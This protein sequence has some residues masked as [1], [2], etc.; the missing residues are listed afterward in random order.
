M[1]LEQARSALNVVSDEPFNA[2]APSE[3]FETSI[4]PTHL[5]F[6]RSNF[7]LPVHDG[8]LAIG[9]AVENSFTLTLDDLR[10]MPR[11]ELVVTLEC[12]G[13]ARLGQ[14]PL[15][16]GEPWHSNAVSAA[17]WAGASLRNVLEKA[18]PLADAVVASFEGADHGPYHQHAD[19]HFARSLP[20]ELALDSASQILIAYEMNGEPLNADHGAPFRLIVP[21]WYAV[22]SVKWLARIDLLTRPFEGTFQAERY[23]YYWNDREAEPVKLMLPRAKIAT[24]VSGA[25]LA[26]GSYTVRGKAWSG[27][28]PITNVDVSLNGRGEWL[29][30]ELEPPA[31][32][33]QW[34]DWSFVWQLQKVGRHTLRARA[35]DAAGN[36]Q[37]E[38]PRW[39]RLGYGNN[40]V[41]LVYAHVR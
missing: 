11:E 30:A 24:P 35:T 6:V 20:L 40:A 21:R 23:I 28:G 8:R 10:A 19:I 32:P 29:A 12:A 22:A 16:A 36:V 25:A 33:Y 39:N 31:G 14:T 4:T 17:R 2:E 34:Q 38:S 13:N 26:A 27:S 37:P 15:P 3:A 5:H 9:G 18:R 1:N 7:A 41:E